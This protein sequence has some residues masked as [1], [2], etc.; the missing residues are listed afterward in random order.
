MG[1]FCFS[2]L[3]W[4]KITFSHNVIKVTK[5][6]DYIDDRFHFLDIT[7]E[8]TCRANSRRK[9]AEFLAVR[10]SD[11]LSATVQF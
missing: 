5:K 4:A 6:D 2:Y 10:F 1:L 8:L 11:W 7:S 9:S 3:P